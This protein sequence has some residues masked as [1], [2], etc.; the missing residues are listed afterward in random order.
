M[1]SKVIPVL[2]TVHEQVTCSHIIAP[3]AAS[4]TYGGPERSAEAWSAMLHADH[5]V[6]R[7]GREWGPLM[8]ALVEAQVVAQLRRGDIPIVLGG[9][10]SLTY[11]SVRGQLRRH[12]RLTVVHFDAHHDRY[13]TP[14]VLTH[15]NVMARMT[16]D[17]GCPVYGVGYRYDVAL[18]EFELPTELTGPVYLSIDLDFFD[19]KIVSS[20]ASA[21][22]VSTEA[23]IIPNFETF[24]TILQSIQCPI[25]GADLVEWCGAA[26]GS[27]EFKV[28]ARVRSE[29]A[30]R[31]IQSR[32]LG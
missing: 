12:P 32:V 1:R 25:V 17:F 9:D 26:P 28:V 5:R 22:D 16:E 7:N 24:S 15:Y 30:Y 19:P 10:H 6:V 27:D 3:Y 8:P 31:A 11:F 18:Q 21:V 13:Q 2:P 20:V 4:S 14:S 29:V 23:P